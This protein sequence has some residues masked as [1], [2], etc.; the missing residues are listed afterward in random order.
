MKTDHLIRT[1]SAD[2]D[3]QARPVGLWLTA[4]LLVAG[5]ISI[6]MF[7]M[8]LHVRPDVATAMRNPFFDLKFAVTLSLAIPAIVLGLRLVRPAAPVGGLMWLLL[9]PVALL[10]MGVAGDFMVPQ[11]LSWSAR[12]V[13]SNSRVC[14]MA[15][16]A[17]SLPLL[18]AALIAFR[19][20]AAT[21]P[22]L[23]GAVAGLMSAGLAATL[24][25]AHC[26]DDSPLFVATWYTLAATLV[27][28]LG[29][30]VGSRF[31]RF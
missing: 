20:G 1:L 27:T 7:M 19:H 8:M 14:M 22:V 13:G 21:R 5:A 25:A 31:L 17:M 23:A 28:C 4:G 30:L 2:N 18:V 3:W 6:S 15:I 26:P 10:A 24:Y 12:L 16:P 11:R 29:A 9:C